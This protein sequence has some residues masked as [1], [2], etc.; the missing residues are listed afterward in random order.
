MSPPLKI[1]ISPSPHVIRFQGEIDEDALFTGI[2]IP[3]DRETVF[4]LNGV[5]LINSCG[6]RE[7]IRWM[8]E[9][10]TGTRLVWENCPKIIVDQINMVD[11]FLPAGAKV[12]SFDVPYYCEKCEKIKIVRFQAGVEFQG[13][14]V[15]APT[16][17]TCD[18]CQGPVELDVIESKYFKFLRVMG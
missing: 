13:A 18:H 15:T 5:R 12:R 2:V 7:W 17:V 8:K 10:K 4:D 11:G 6:I 14:T 1:E 9:I 3:D 16:A